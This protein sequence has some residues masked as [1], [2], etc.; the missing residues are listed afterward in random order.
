MTDPDPR[1]EAAREANARGTAL[2]DLGRYAEAMAHY[3]RAIELQP[4]R[5]A[6]YANLGIAC[7]HLGDFP[8]SL[9]ASLRALELDPERAGSGVLWNVGIAATALADWPRARE[10]WSK[11]G[12]VVPPGEG[13]LDMDIGST[14]IRVGPGPSGTKNEVVWCHRIDPVRARIESIPTPESGRRF[15]D[16]LLHDGEPTG[17]RRVGGPSGA[18]VSVFDELAVLEPSPYR[19]FVL[20]L[21]APGPDD[22]D[23]LYRTF[24]D[25]PHA[26]LEDFTASL[27]VMCAACSR[28][29]PHEEHEDAQTPW[30]PK[31]RVAIATLDPG[32]FAHLACWVSEGPGRAASPPMAM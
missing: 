29:L 15:G 21:V 23:A 8:R 10:A 31:R 19:T 28:G 13:P 20:D 3:E 30:S 9:S 17:K 6:A 1:R 7:K 18:E 25:T 24:A 5:Y 11:V 4:D 16:L 14:P 26:A 27:N 12:I 32:V 2:A 22:L